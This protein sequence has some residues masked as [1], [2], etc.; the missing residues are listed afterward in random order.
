MSSARDAVPSSGNGDSLP[1]QSLTSVKKN[2]RMTSSNA[3]PSSGY[4][5][6]DVFVYDEFARA[7]NTTDR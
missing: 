6:S 7:E 2:K 5:D 4:A 3:V 1:T